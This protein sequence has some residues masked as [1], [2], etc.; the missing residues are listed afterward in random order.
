MVRGKKIEATIF[1]KTDISNMSEINHLL[2]KK[3][4]SSE[5]EYLTC[6]LHG[7]GPNIWLRRMKYE[8]NNKKVID[9]NEIIELAII[10]VFTAWRNGILLCNSRIY[11]YRKRAYAIIGSGSS[12]YAP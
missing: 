9:D 7:S 6:Q 8:N 2:C 10:C 1:K 12:V 11:F 5:S 4:P 3:Q